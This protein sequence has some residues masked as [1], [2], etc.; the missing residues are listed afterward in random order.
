MA[1][2][3]ISGLTSAAAAAAANEF[4]INEAGTSKKVTG[5]QI[6]T[7]VG[8]TLDGDKGDITV[9]GS[10]AT[11]T[12]DALA[13]TSGKL[14]A[15]AATL[16]KLDTTGALGKVLT[17][18]GSGVAPTWESSS[19]GRSDA[20]Y[21]TLTTGTLNVTLT[22]ASNQLQVISADQEGCSVTLPDMTTLTKGSGYFYFYNTSL[23]SIAVKD[24]GGT[25]REYLQPCQNLGS[26]PTQIPSLPLNIE[27]ISSANGVWHIQDSVSAG[28]YNT[29]T[30]GVFT[31]YTLPGTAYLYQTYCIINS[32]QFLIAYASSIGGNAGIPYLQLVTIDTSTKALTFATPVSLGSVGS[33]N[34]IQG[35]NI[36]S[37]GSDR[38]LVSVITDQFQSN[39]A[40][41]GTRHYG[42]AVVS[43]V[44]YVSTSQFGPS[45]SDGMGSTTAGSFC[46]YSGSS[47]WF[48]S[49]SGKAGTLG[50]NYYAYAYQVN[51]ASTTVTLATATGNGANRASAGGS[52]TYY[53]VSPTSQTTFVAETNSG[54]NPSFIN[55]NT[56]TNTISVGA[57]TSQ[58][59][60]IA[61]TLIPMI[62][63]GQG[64]NLI[65]M[66]SSGSKMLYG[67]P[68]EVAYSTTNGGY[69]VAVANTGTA[70]VTVSFTTATYK[71]FASKNYATIQNKGRV[72]NTVSALP[73]I[74]SSYTVSASSVWFVGDN[75]T[76]INADPTN[77]S[78]NMNYEHFN[79]SV[80]SRRSSE[81]SLVLT[82]VTLYLWN[83]ATTLACVY[84]DLS[85][86][87]TNYLT[88]NG[89]FCSVYSLPTPFV[90]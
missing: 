5:A 43:N 31:A 45:F 39:T 65:L 72:G 90:S 44:L 10:G 88:F 4:E 84:L 55:F 26:A 18:Q 37:N 14:A 60:P 80:G 49:C 12:V 73:N 36:D 25:I 8:T 79:V 40:A 76:I 66:N 53:N 38:G 33:L 7:Y 87:T 16:A 83:S 54:T 57:R 86:T 77:A 17:A 48:I 6:A 35:I 47:N 56:G 71:N 85:S 19:A 69:C 30:S 21:V 23:F 28:S 50:T 78:Y 74:L 67:V 11:W 20:S 89:G 27:D 29:N 82:P 59:T 15:G 22:S 1:N 46:Q 9:S 32:T 62:T 75:S 13:I 51:V 81:N 61:N 64:R 58:T 3:K 34:R 2:V 42:W 70:T 52:G 24:A 68:S 63:S 41:T